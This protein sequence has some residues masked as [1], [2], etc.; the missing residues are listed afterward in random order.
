MKE[1]I[2]YTI[3]NEMCMTV[4]DLLARRSRDL[5]LDAAKAMKLAPKVASLM[6]EE[7]G[8]DRAWINQQ[9]DNFN[10]IAENYLTKT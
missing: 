5:F 6:A 10:K 9:I 2:R 1:F 7:M 8:K 3:Q 4:E